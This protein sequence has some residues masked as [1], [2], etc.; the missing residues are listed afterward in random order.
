MT[1]P[2]ATLPCP[3]QLRAHPTQKKAR[4][5]SRYPSRALWAGVG[6]VA[7]LALSRARQR[8]VHAAGDAAL[9]AAATGR[10]DSPELG[11]ARITAHYAPG[12]GPAAQSQ[13]TGGETRLATSLAVDDV[14]LQQ[15]RRKR[16][17]AMADPSLGFARMHV[18]SVGWLFEGGTL[19][20]TFSPLAEQKVA[21]ARPF[22]WARGG[23]S[24]DRRD[25]SRPAAGR[26][27]RGGD[28]CRLLE[29]ETRGRSA[30]D[31]QAHF[32]GGEIGSRR[33]AAPDALSDE[34]AP[35]GEEAAAAGAVEDA[36]AQNA[37][38][39]AEKQATPPD[40]AAATEQHGAHITP[41]T[42]SGRCRP[43]SGFPQPR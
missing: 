5:V 42:R 15:S 7:G 2:H 38:M 12:C 31:A 18:P 20:K 11:S 28:R 4:G 16:V 13:A 30:G 3:P 6:R 21:A 9:T 8:W 29:E 22:G 26:G 19:Q 1:Q 17:P 43:W 10:T 37:H 25:A 32:E 39:H 35:A 33:E 23:L 41:M 34:A 24:N 40:E 14:A 36:K 27:G